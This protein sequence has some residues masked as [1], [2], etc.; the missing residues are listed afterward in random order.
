[1][2]VGPSACFIFM[3]TAAPD[4]TSAHR[5]RLGRAHDN[6][7]VVNHAS[8]SS[9]HAELEEL[10]GGGFLLRDTGSRNGTF[11]GRETNRITE[12]V[13]QGDEMLWFSVGYKI[14]LPLLLQQL[15]SQRP[16]ADAG[17]QVSVDRNV[18][19]IGR[20]ADNEIRL[21]QLVAS[22]YHAEIHRRPDGS[23]WIQDLGSKLGT[24]VGKRVIR[25]CE[26]PLERDE[27][28][29][30][31]GERISVSFADKAKPTGRLAVNRAGHTLQIEGLTY[32][33]NGTRRLVDTVNLVMFPGELVAIMGPSGCGKSTLLN[34]CSGETKPSAGRVMYDGVELYSAPHSIL[35]FVGHVP[36]DD[37]LPA[38]LTVNEILLA[39]ARIRLPA[40]VQAAEIEAKIADV[41]R[42]IGLLDEERGIDLRYQL[43]GSAERKGL[44]GGQKKR[45][46]LAM[47]LLSD[48]RIIFLD[49]PTSGLSS[50]DA[51]LVI[52]LLRQVS[53]QKGI[54]I[55]VTIHQPA[56]GVYKLFD[57]VV[58]LKSGRLAFFG[59][60]FPDAVEFFCPG[61][62]PE[63]AGPD[64]IMEELDQK[65]AAELG[66]R[67]ATSLYAT[68][69][70][71]R[72]STPAEPIEASH[73]SVTRRLTA[74]RY[75]VWAVFRRDLR[76]K[77][78]DRQFLAILAAQPLMIGVLV[79]QLFA[80][81]AGI[82]R[83]TA[84]FV[85]A[86]VSFWFGLNLAARELVAERPR[87]RREK[88]GGL[89]PFGY[90]AS[91]AAILSLLTLVQVVVLVGLLS[92]QISTLAWP[93]PEVLLIGWL[94]AF[95]G[96]CAGMITSSTARSEIGAV[97]IVP[98]QLIPVILLGGLLK[99]YNPGLTDTVLSKLLSD[100]T[101]LRWSFE[102]FS[103][104]CDATGLFPAPSI[105]LPCSVIALMSVI[106]LGCSWWRVCRW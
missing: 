90:V 52:E 74:I 12:A 64:A 7:F 76:A 43:V 21:T 32:V 69:Y 45:V 33:I 77:S 62:P 50:Y 1:M 97:A 18:I 61:Q 24:R 41:C 38:D 73:A 25:D 22:R 84:S 49:E 4:S 65:P 42:S 13:L 87:I 78:R 37:L 71:Q 2:A 6:D 86:L 85:C 53:V 10:G 46:G 101:P 99:S 47:E 35:P 5:W 31:C 36:Q 95:C 82:E 23:L 48:P 94:T 8:V 9:H 11:V 54:A 14:P 40:D 28:I 103:T 58:F 72:R 83:L 91:K 56:L 96:V 100:M 63:R 39:H 44:S 29:E 104:A 81:A 70:F 102:A 20:A 98:L 67:Y 34:L 92:L 93:F 55:I 51:K 66:D 15:R 30:I 79:G 89:S 105:G 27:I 57:S 75:Q 16:V 3:N 60:A 17:R 19:R 88:R 59:P 68:K 26:V 106:G 80:S